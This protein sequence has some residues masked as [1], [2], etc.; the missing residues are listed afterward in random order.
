MVMTNPL[1][2]LLDKGV[3]LDLLEIY[4]LKQEDGYISISPFRISGINFEF[5]YCKHNLCDFTGLEH[6]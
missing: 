6:N 1:S 5:Y 4:D 3:P 2:Q